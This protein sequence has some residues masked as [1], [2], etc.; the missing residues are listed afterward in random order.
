MWSESSV[1]NR[2]AAR[3]YA[4]D[5]VGSQRV[6]RRQLNTEVLVTRKSFDQT[7]PRKKMTTL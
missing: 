1:T 3:Q 2:N 5:V 6:A 7:P 4:Q